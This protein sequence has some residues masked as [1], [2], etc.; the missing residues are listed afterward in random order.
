MIPVHQQT[1]KVAL[2]CL[3][4]F[5][6]DISALAGRMVVFIAVEADNVPFNSE[7][8][9]MGLAKWQTGAV[10]LTNS[11]AY[12]HQQMAYVER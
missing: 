2:D 10:K 5:H 6:A 1:A 8:F 12:A 11:Q 4:L 9:L 3:R 7:E